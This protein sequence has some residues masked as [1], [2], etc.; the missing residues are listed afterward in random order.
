MLRPARAAGA[1]LLLL[2]VAVA[3]QPDNNNNTAITTFS[4]CTCL[5]DA[6]GFGGDTVAA[7]G[8]ACFDG[9]A[10]TA[11]LP[12]CLVSRDTCQHAPASLWGHQLLDGAAKQLAW[13]VCLD[14]ADASA[15]QLCAVPQGRSEA[16]PMMWLVPARRHICRHHAGGLHMPAG[17]GPGRRHHARRRLPG[18]LDALTA[19]A[20]WHAGSSLTPSMAA[21]RLQ[22]TTPDE[23]P[24]CLVL[25]GSCATPP[26]ARATSFHGGW[27][28]C[29]GANDTTANSTGAATTGGG[30]PSAS[31]PPLGDVTRANCTCLPEW[32]YSTGEGGEEGG[33][34]GEAQVLSGCA[35]PDQDP[36]EWRWRGAGRVACLPLTQR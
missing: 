28:W 31:L 20:S 12:W 19:C 25:P 6:P 9:T 29:A 36:R 34:A 18:A 13:D 32:L 30:P 23:Q 24:W 21:P 14:A 4:G 15:C 33:V 11:G 2:M 17:L 22:S 26:A 8:G 35:L 5:P 10:D 7:R 3:A 27:D 16:R 1:V